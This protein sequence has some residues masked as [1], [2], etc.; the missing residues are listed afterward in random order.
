MSPSRTWPRRRSRS[1]CRSAI[2]RPL[3]TRSSSRL[4]RGEARSPD[5]EIGLLHLRVLGEC[6]RGAREHALADLEHGGE[7][8]DFERKLDRLLGEQDGQALAMQ[9]AE[10][11]VHGFDHRRRKA[12]RWL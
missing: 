5:A 8:G 11:L 3:T 9:A 6:R 2:S 4:A 7:I 12:K 1:R 10:G